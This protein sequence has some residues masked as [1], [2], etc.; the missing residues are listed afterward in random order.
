MHAWPDYLK[1]AG[2]INPAAFRSLV[3]DHRIARLQSGEQ[4]GPVIAAGSTGSI[5]STARLLKC[6]AGMENGCVILPG[7]DCRLP[8]EIIQRLREPAEM[9]G[10]TA[11]STHPQFAMVRQLAEMGL[12]HDDVVE[13]ASGDPCLGARNRISNICLRPAE[14]TGSWLIERRA[15]DE[16]DL[17]EAFENVRL[18]EARGE[19]EEAMAIALVLREV[20]ATPEK[21]AAL[22]TPDRELARRVSAELER[23]GIEIDDSAGY[24]LT[25]APAALQARHLMRIVFD[26]GD[27]ASWSG[28]FKS[29]LAGQLCGT[30]EWGRQGD[31]FELLLIR[32]CL[33]LPQA[34]NLYDAVQT[35]KARLAK[36]RHAPK[37]L[38]LIHI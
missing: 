12:S 13:I 15:F 29:R 14:D 1:S 20:L 6:I 22:V 2:K 4:R 36:T 37:L 16:T 28:F 26:G 33:S 32:D 27:A 3:A 31:L 23:F 25:H 19:R 5:P 30:R 8:K 9:S 11:S 7:L 18:I 10:E 17:T 35:A 24:P 38:S 34:G 21:T